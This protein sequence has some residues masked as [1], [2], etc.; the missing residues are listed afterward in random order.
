MKRNILKTTL[1]SLT[2]SALLLVSCKKEDDKTT[3]PTTPAVKSIYEIA[4]SDTS[5]SILVAAL[6]KAGLK[7]TLS[8]SGTFTVFAP[9][10]EAFRKED[11]S[12]ELIN[13]ITN[14]EQIL[15]LKNTLLYHVLGSKVKSTEVQNAY[16]STL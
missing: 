13:S 9:N 3:T 16:V 2:A 12:V 15:A 1:L 6:D 8:N 11:V 4:K 5:F 10:N 14:P 7:E